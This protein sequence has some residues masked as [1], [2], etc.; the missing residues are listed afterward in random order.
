MTLYMLI[1]R[2]IKP[3]AIIIDPIEEYIRPKK[4]KLLNSYDSTTDFNSNI[5]KLFYIKDELKKILRE[6]SNDAERVWRSRILY[7]STPR[8]NIVMHYDIYK[9]GF[10]YYADQNSIPYSILNAVAMKYVMVFFCRDFFF[11]EDV[12]T[13]ERIS[14]IFEETHDKKTNKPDTSQQFAKFKQYRSNATP[15]EK[16]DKNNDKQKTKPLM[17]NK[18]ISLGKIYNFNILNK[19]KQKPTFSTD[20]QTSFSGM[21]GTN[22]SYKNFKNRQTTIQEEQPLSLS[23]TI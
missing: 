11:D 16:T 7:E 18:F 23:T 13:I 12:I 14:K 21:F 17:K 9:Q 6:E 10:A 4:L 1:L 15:T 3:P 2:K 8:G 5:D 20:K 22:M 19:P